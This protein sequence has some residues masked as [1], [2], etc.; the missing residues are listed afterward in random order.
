[1]Q[2]IHIHPADHSPAASAA[3]AARMI[4]GNTT[5]YALRAVLHVASHNGG[6]PV[7]VDDIAE[8]LRLP[9]NYLSK[10]LH[11]LARAGILRSGRGPKGGFQLARPAH[12]ITFA[13]IAA[14]FND[15]VEPRCLLGRAQC[16]WKNPCSAHP[17]WE[18]IA[19]SIREFFGSTTIADLLGEIAEKPGMAPNRDIAHDEIRTPTRGPARAT[20]P[21]NTSSRSAPRRKTKD[22]KS[23]TRR[24]RSG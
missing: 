15:L 24:K 17:R 7:R 6:E 2:A 3:H 9:R 10:T 16:G 4:L 13:D 11:A 14:P 8:A 18:T 20:S 22:K 19:S 12:D 1:M 21:A 5:Q 23:P